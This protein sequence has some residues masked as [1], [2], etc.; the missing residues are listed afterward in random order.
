[1]P[2]RRG[3]QEETKSPPQEAD[4]STVELRTRMRVCRLA[5]H[6]AYFSGN[7]RHWIFYP[8]LGEQSLG[9]G[10]WLMQTAPPRAC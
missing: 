9:G 4:Q 3:K 5:I 7:A 10:S 1:M 6:G 8:K 2:E